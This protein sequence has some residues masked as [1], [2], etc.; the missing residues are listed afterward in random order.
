MKKAYLL[1]STIAMTASPYTAQAQTAAAPAAT[2]PAPATATNPRNGHD[3]R[4]ATL[5][6]DTSSAMITTTIIINN[7]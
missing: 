5:R 1:L 2:A 7:N 6:T 4:P 3:A